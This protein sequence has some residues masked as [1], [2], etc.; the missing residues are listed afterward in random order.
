MVFEEGQVMDQEQVDKTFM[1]IMQ[2]LWSADDAAYMHMVV[3]ATIEHE[4]KVSEGD[5]V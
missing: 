4:R 3:E 2:T 5:D 1:A